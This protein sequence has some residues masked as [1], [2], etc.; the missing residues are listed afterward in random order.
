MDPTTNNPWLAGVRNSA[1]TGS[2]SSNATLWE[3]DAQSGNVRRWVDLNKTQNG[4][5]VAV[6]PDG[7]IALATEYVS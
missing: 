2:G 1:W 3:L 5:G 7:L 6:N 4:T